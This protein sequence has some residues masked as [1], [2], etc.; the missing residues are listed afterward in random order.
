MKNQVWVASINHAPVI[1]IDWDGQRYTGFI[2]GKVITFE[3]H[4]DHLPAEAW[5]L[6]D[7][8]LDGYLAN[9][10]SIINGIHGGIA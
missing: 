1:R 6:F 10:D 2:R 3:E 4:L 9:R 7:E 8:V 5:A